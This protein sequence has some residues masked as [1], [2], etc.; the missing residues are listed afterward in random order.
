MIVGYDLVISSIIVYVENRLETAILYSEIEKETGFSLAHIRDVFAQ[1]TGRTLSKYI[2]ERKICNAAFCISHTT[3][4]LL[5]I[6]EKFGFTNPDTFTRAF[7]RIVGITP[8]EFRKM[9][10]PVGRIKLC[11]GV[12]GVGFMPN[13]LKKIRGCESNE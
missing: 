6:A 11:T 8:S 2:L 5:T 12:Y 9:K 3:E 1:R 13:E 7:R 10:I 4:S